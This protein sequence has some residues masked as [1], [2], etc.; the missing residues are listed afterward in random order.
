[1]PGGSSSRRRYRAGMHAAVRTTSCGKLVLHSI[2]HTCL[3]LA[4]RGQHDV[5]SH[6]RVLKCTRKA[7]RGMS[8]PSRSFLRRCVREVRLHAVSPPSQHRLLIAKIV[9]AVSVKQI[10]KNRH[11]PSLSVWP[12]RSR[13]IP[14]TIVASRAEQSLLGT[15]THSI[16]YMYTRPSSLSVSPFYADVNWPFG[17]WYCT[18]CW[19]T[20]YSCSY[21]CL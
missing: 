10:S 1:M 20:G 2:K 13:N 12:I 19:V 11:M 16:S 14:H 7:R 21:R 15:I 4:R 9:C 6:R 8:P 3:R 5:R 18:R 17:E